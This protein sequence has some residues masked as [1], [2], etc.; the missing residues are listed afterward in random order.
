MARPEE[1]MRLKDKIIDNISKAIKS[2]QSHHFYKAPGSTDRRDAGYSLG[3]I[4][5]P[6]H[7]L[8]EN[9]DHAFLHG[10]KNV[11]HGYWPVVKQLS[12][13]GMIKE[14]EMLINVTTDLGR[15]RAWLYASLNEGLLESYLRMLDEN[16]KLVKKYYAK[17]AL[18]LDH[19]R[20]NLLLTLITGLECVTFQLDFDQPYLDLNAYPPRSRSD[21][22]LEESFGQSPLPLD[23]DRR[24]SEVSLT[25]STCGNAA[26][27][28]SDSD[29]SSL[30][31]VDV[32][33]NSAGLD[34]T[35]PGTAQQQSASMRASTI[36]SDS[37][38]P[39]RGSGGLEVQSPLSASFSSFNDAE[40]RS[41]T[42]TGLPSQQKRGSK[43]P[44][45]VSVS[46]VGSSGDPDRIMRVEH[47]LPK[48]DHGG[49]EDV[50][51][52]S[53]EVIRVKS[54]RGS[55]NTKG[56]KKK[57]ER[58]NDSNV[59]QIKD[60]ASTVN[61][62]ISETYPK[63]LN[64]GSGAESFDNKI[65][66]NDHGSKSYNVSGDSETKTQSATD[67]LDRL[68]EKVSTDHNPAS[69]P[70]FDSGVDIHSILVSE[71][72][73]TD[74]TRRSSSEGLT[75]KSYD[76]SKSA[77]AQIENKIAELCFVP[78]E[79]HVPSKRP[80]NTSDI[81]GLSDPS[82]IINQDSLI[83]KE[84]SNLPHHLEHSN[85][86]DHTTHKSSAHIPVETS[87]QSQS[88]R[89][90]SGVSDFA[91]LNTLSSPEDMTDSTF[92]SKSASQNF[93]S[94]SQHNALISETNN[95]YQEDYQLY[96]AKSDTSV[97]NPDTEDDFDFYACDD[98][99]ADQEETTG[100]NKS[101]GMSAA[102]A[103][104]TSAHAASRLDDYMDFILQ[105][106]ESPPESHASMASLDFDK[107]V[108]LA[109]ALDNNTK[110][111]V[112]LD[113]FT[114]EHEKFIKMFATRENH[115]E[116][117]P[118]PVFVVI[119]DHCLYL[120]HYKRTRRR[121]TLSSCA[122]LVDLIFVSTGLND[123][124]LNI[125]SREKNRQKQRLWLT[126]GHQNLTQAILACLTD[127]V[128]AAN[129]H[130]VSVRSR[131]SVGSEVPLQKIALRKYISKELNSEAQ[132]VTVGDYSLVFW[133]DPSSD[134]DN[135]ANAAGKEGTLLL[136]SHDAIKGF[137][138]KPVYVVLKDSMLCVSNHKTDVRPHSYLG[139]GGD[140][141]VGCRLVSTAD[142][143]HCVELVLS[144]GSGGSW[145]LSAASEQ[146][147]SEWRHSLCLAVSQ[148]M[149][150][151]GV[152]VW[153]WWQL[154]SLCL[155]ISQGMQVSGVTIWFWWQLVSLCLAIS[156]GLQV[157]GV[158]ISQGM[159]VSGVT[160]SQGMQVSGVT[161]SQ[162]MHVSGVIVSQGMQVSGVTV[163]QGLQVSGVTIS[164]GMQVSGVTVS[165]G[166]QDPNSLSSCIP[167][168]AVLSCNQLFMCHEDLHTKFFRTLGR[169][170]LE[171]VTGISVD[172]QEPTYCIIE[173][174]SQEVG[175][176]SVQWVLY[177]AS[178]IDRDR[179]T[180]AMSSAW[181]EIYKIDLPVA[182][183]ENVALQRHCRSYADLLRKQLTL[184]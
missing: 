86:H 143:P 83:S 175:V 108:D 179:H 35:T 66:L 127:A 92:K 39:A 32:H 116:G 49:D 51:G 170:Q 105:G 140:Q 174:E 121:F 145:F 141:C 88:T 132:D 166:M 167:C 17:E 43:A 96:H 176:S 57:K 155:T 139:L 70:Q 130:I 106:A 42:P 47:I 171:D 91:K 45:S 119:S 18:L 162:G 33:S 34:P 101:V 146:E 114:Q 22:E 61:S 165:Q 62:Q 29:S 159:Q 183:M 5:K 25:S 158:T 157:S 90:L 107:P 144:S 36:S 122:N 73:P 177:F 109:L 169:A 152:T 28:P 178:S 89:P 126:P 46:S 1:R 180:A 8:C 104:I 27:G 102:T 16:E 151:S 168:C 118:T 181:K 7:K 58:T 31:S 103:Q 24:I 134:T 75:A 113:I 110:L 125:E 59:A 149:Q 14:I 20:L 97:Y 67:N 136:R 71:N 133:E 85:L 147:I 56:K 135:L 15:G 153:F 112:M 98:S 124:T 137:V 129:E 172:A 131:F 65:N 81:H 69:I 173:F 11:S 21:S 68:E 82:D 76:S 30:A 4:D 6:C 164:Q 12:H 163:S 94:D 79:N 100:I 148:G 142:R 87:N 156:Q 123:Q 72:F 3:N 184:A 52:T 40:R 13:K 182:P 99:E 161:V 26:Q 160:V 84:K 23:K 77:F 115:T 50:D 48:R 63:D 117:E 9:L 2:I 55:G 60:R 10:L 93:G 54:K 37:G 41:I 128:K 53:L 95:V 154:V 64:I 38:Y 74:K 150:V 44:D 138:W 111:Q 120:L 80:V 78:E 19:D